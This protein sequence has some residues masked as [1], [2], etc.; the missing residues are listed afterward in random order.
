MAVL[1]QN[2]PVGLG[3]KLLHDV[4]LGERLFKG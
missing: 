4:D 3:I 1:S 2:S